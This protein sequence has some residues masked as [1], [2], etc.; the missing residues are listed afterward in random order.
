MNQTEA[1]EQYIMSKKKFKNR[2][3]YICRAK[4]SF[5]CYASKGRVMG[6]ELTELLVQQLGL[7]CPFYFETPWGEAMIAKEGDYIVSPIDRTEI[8]RIARKEF[9]KLIELFKQFSYLNP[10]QRRNALTN[11]QK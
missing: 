3:H 2:Y 7:S 9:L 1:G 4:G 10:S 6:I 11:P 5:N 8:Y